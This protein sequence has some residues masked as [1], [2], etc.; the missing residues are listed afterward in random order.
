MPTKKQLESMDERVRALEKIQSGG[1]DWLAKEMQGLFHNDRV[2]GSAVENHDTTIAALKA[3][4]IEKGIITEDEVE[5][6][7]KE[8]DDLR[9]KAEKARAK[10]AE[11]KNAAEQLKKQALEEQGHPSEAFIFGG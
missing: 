6:K 5:A 8:I 9:A 1:I 2:I 7:R 4:L 11:F 3:L 10:E